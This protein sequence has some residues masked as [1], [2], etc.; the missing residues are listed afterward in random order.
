MCNKRI[1][2]ILGVQG[3]F[4]NDVEINNDRLVIDIEREDLTYC[5]SN[6]GQEH[7]FYYDK[8]TQIIRDLDISGKEVYLRLDRHR[9]LCDCE[10][11]PQVIVERLR[12]VDI[13][14]RMTKR[15]EAYVYG[16][17]RKMTVKDVSEELGIHWNSVKEIEKKFIKKLR[18]GIRWKK[19]KRLAIDE[20][21][22]NG[23]REFLTIVTDRDGQGVVWIGNGKG[24]D[25]LDKFFEYVGE[26]RY[27]RFKVFTVDMSKS[28]TASIKDYC[29]DAD[30][31][32]DLFHLIRMLNKQLNEIRASEMARGREEGKS[33]HR[34]DKWL[35]LKGKER[36]T[37]GQKIDLKELLEENKNIQKGYLLKEMLREIFK[38][39]T[40]TVET[41]TE[42][43][44]NWTVEA[45]NTGL[46]ALQSF[47]KTI[48]SHFDGIVTYFRYHITNSIAEGLNN[49]I[50]ELS[51]SAY[52]YRDK[53]YFKLKIIQHLSF[54]ADSVPL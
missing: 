47:C 51:R 21:S 43:I 39:R 53:E 41:L 50:K 17:T 22:W 46:K 44:K 52:G 42:R 16:L 20:V 29:P 14:R 3:F 49:V 54:V 11:M 37:V 27:K 31:V 48:V 15:F 23:G 32:Y 30:I 25:T 6:C 35:L 33:Y 8:R 4:V 28:Y 19:I 18:H 24:K 5:C 1:T 34:N 26:E 38:E 2:E 9:V 10:K 12:F 7:F 36:L 40:Q 45:W 13:H